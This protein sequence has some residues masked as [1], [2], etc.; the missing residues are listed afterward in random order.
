MVGQVSVI[1]AETIEKKIY[2]LRR[3]K[4]MLSPD[5]AELYQVEPRA[6]IQAVK[7]NIERFPQDF[8]FQLTK[9]EFANLKSQFVISSWGGLRRAYP[10]AFTEQGVAMLSS[11]LNSPRAIKVNIEIMRAFVRL[12]RMLASH[13]ELAR[14]LDALEK[15]YDSQFKVVFE[16]IRQ[17]MAPKEAPNKKI[18]FQLKEK[19][20]S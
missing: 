8:M 6:L 7:R 18:G 5:L 14:K 15:K 3:Q 1:P 16:A 17:L 20:A 10:Y 9:E 13:A 11:V 4:V 19:R 2:L 12:R